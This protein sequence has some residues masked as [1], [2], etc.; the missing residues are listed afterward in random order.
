M[1]YIQYKDI[2]SLYFPFCNSK[3]SHVTRCVTAFHSHVCF[4]LCACV[5]ICEVS[6]LTH[7]TA[8]SS[9]RLT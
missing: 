2:T 6:T 1:S 3:L 9:L 8:L 7:P 4:F 5:Y